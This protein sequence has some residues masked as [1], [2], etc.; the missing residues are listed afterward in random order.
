LAFIPGF[1]DLASEN[2][3]IGHLIDVGVFLILR[4]FTGE[5]ITLR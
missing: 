5:A 2:P 3:I 1:Q 4:W